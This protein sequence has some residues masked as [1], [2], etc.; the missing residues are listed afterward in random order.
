MNK[1][2]YREYPP[3]IVLRDYSYL[4]N[5]NVKSLENYLNFYFSQP[6][7][8]N[9]VNKVF[10]PS[11]T[12]QNGLNFISKEDEANLTKEDF[13]TLPAHQEIINTFKIIL[14]LLKQ[15]YEMFEDKE[16]PDALITNIM[17]KFKIDSL[18][19]INFFTILI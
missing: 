1:N 6:E 15:N 5:D 16:L 2:V 12:A 14:I 3:R 17:K 10:A 18:S 7:N 11:K 8:E 4:L 19:K 9:K 13:S